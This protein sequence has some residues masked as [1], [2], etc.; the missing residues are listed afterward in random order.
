MGYI[1]NDINQLLNILD[2]FLKNCKNDD[3]KINILNIIRSKIHEY[4]PLNEEPV[5]CVLWVKAEK[6][7]ANDY[8]PNAMAPSEKRLLTLSIEADGFTQPVVVARDGEEHYRVVDGFHRYMIGKKAKGL[9]RHLKG[10]LPVTIIRSGRENKALRIAATIRHNRARGKHQ[11]ASMSD[12]VKDLARQGWSDETIGK[13]LG[14][15]KD[16]VLRLKQ[17]SGLV[18]LF[19]CETFSE[20]WTVR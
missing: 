7:L 11:T 16:E 13:E 10:Y 15:D 18:E 5:D 2:N 17:I 9:G 14:M 20:A 1:M 4:S 12:I 19:S 3:E 8:N 6:I